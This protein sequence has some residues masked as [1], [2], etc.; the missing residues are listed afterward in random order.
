VTQS[1]KLYTCSATFEFSQ[2]KSFEP[3]KLHSDKSRSGDAQ[4]RFHLL[5]LVERSQEDET[6]N[7]FGEGGGVQSAL[8]GS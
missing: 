1:F 2:N 6:P 8:L 3:G 7:D 5:K 4:N